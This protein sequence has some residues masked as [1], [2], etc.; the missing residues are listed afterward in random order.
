MNV[1]ENPFFMAFKIFQDSNN[2]TGMT[3]VISPDM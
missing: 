3:T 1:S 2:S